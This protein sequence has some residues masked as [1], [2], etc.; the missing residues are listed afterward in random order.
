VR[1]RSHAIVACVLVVLAFGA[2]LRFHGY[3]RTWRLWNIPVM[4]PHF[5]DLRTITHGAD[6]HAR[7]LDPMRENPIDPWQRRLDYPRIWQGLYALGVDSGATTALGVAVILLFLIG[8]CLILPDADPP[9]LAAVFL[10]VLSP[11]VLF[12]VERG[13]ID[14]LMFF[15]VAVAAVAVRRS[16]V[17][18]GAALAAGFVLKLFPLFGAA[19]LVRAGRSRFRRAAAVLAVFAAAYLLA[20]WADLRLMREASLRSTSLSYGLDVLWRKV[21]ELDATA[22]GV[23]RAASYAAVVVIGASVALAAMRPGRPPVPQG[24]LA[25]DAFRAGAAVYVGS[26]LFDVN[27]DYRLVFLVLCMPQ[28]VAWSRSRAAA[29]ARPTLAAAYLAL[30]SLVIGGAF[31]KVPGGGAAWLVLEEVAT[32][33]VFAGLLFLLLR[34]APEWLKEDARGGRPPKPKAG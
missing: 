4:T 25:L 20:T 6:A 32:W 33:V 29:A 14:L 15:L 8:V 12:G 1:S 27:W 13:N 23:V 16:A 30:W 11:A 10:A 5:A 21:A 7:G 3:E 18:A 34:S 2:L 19:V 26:F 22:G 9:T 24:G 31:G 28:L 17:A